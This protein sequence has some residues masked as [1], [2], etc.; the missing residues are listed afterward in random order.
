MAAGSRKNK[1]AGFVI[2]FLALFFVML[3]RGTESNWGGGER[4]AAPSL[5]K[6]LCSHSAGA[7]VHRPQ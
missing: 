5:F 6:G 4:L 1:P 2:F 7:I 3:N